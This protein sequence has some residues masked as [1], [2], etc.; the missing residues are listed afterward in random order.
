MVVVTTF[1]FAAAALARWI[2]VALGLIGH[3]LSPMVDR[4]GR[5]QPGGHCDNY[6]VEN[7]W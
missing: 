2:V 6:R 3:D 4:Y 7:I 1:P 5:A